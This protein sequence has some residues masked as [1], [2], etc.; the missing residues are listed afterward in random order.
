MIELTTL[1]EPEPVG[2]MVKTALAY[3]G[4]LP[5]YD[6]MFTGV[7]NSIGNEF[8][9]EDYTPLLPGGFDPLDGDVGTY[10]D[11]LTGALPDRGV[12][13]VVAI[14][15]VNS[16]ESWTYDGYEYDMWVEWTIISANKFPSF[17]ELKHWFKKWKKLNAEP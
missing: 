15:K 14:G 13:D 11:D 5:E 4:K 3:N 1:K 17:G 16:S 7:W 8:L 9:T 6:V 2:D 10:I 12:W